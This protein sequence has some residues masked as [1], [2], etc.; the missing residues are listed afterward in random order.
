LD[1]GNC[2]DGFFCDDFRTDEFI[3][4]IGLVASSPR[5]STRFFD[6][7]RRSDRNLSSLTLPPDRH[8]KV[9]AYD[10]LGVRVDARLILNR[11][12]WP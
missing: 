8:R 4:A 6:V 9:F 10:E 3:S 7:N 12:L 1:L 2:D 5:Y 11:L